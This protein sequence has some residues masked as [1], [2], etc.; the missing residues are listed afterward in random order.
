M[1]S[2]K[3]NSPSKYLNNANFKVRGGL[4]V[5]FLVEPGSNYRHTLKIDRKQ[6]FAK[7][8]KSIL[9][10]KISCSDS[11]NFHMCSIYL[12][13]L[14]FLQSISQECTLIDMIER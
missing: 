7:S 10:F 6:L 13:I 14:A 2:K 1:I 9:F 8:A 12:Q 3:F 5:I 11:H 4:L